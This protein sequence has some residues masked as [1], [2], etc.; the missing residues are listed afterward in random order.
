MAD[1]CT[2]MTVVP[3]GGI[4]RS[5]AGPLGCGPTD[6]CGVAFAVAVAVEPPPWLDVDAAVAD[7]ASGAGADPLLDEGWLEAPPAAVVGLDDPP[8]AAS[9][10]TSDPSPVAAAHPLLRITSPIPRDGSRCS[11]PVVPGR[12]ASRYKGFPGRQVPGPGT[13]EP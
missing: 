3:T 4:D 13:P 1:F 8:H 2:I 5:S 7:D 10:S 12:G 9:S 11:G 6:L